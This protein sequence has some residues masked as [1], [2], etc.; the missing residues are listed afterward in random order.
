MYPLRRTGLVNQ[1]KIVSGWPFANVITVSQT[2][3]DADYSTIAAAITAASAGDVI[4]IDAGTYTE[5]ITVN[6]AIALTSFD[7]NKTEITTTS[8]ITISLTTSDIVLSNLKIIN[9]SSGVQGN[10]I[11][12]SSSADDC[13]VD[14]CILENNTAGNTNNGI[15]NVSGTGLVVRETNITIS[16]GTSSNFCYNGNTAANDVE[17]IRSKLDASGAGAAEIRLNH[18]NAFATITETI[19]INGTVAINANLG[20]FNGT[21]QDAILTKNSSGATAAFNDVGF[22]DVAGEYQTT[23]TEA[24]NVVW[25]VVVIGNDDD[26]NIFVKRRGNA[27]VNYTGAAPSAGDFLITSTTGG[28]ATQQVTMRSEIFAVATANGSGGTVMA[29]LLTGTESKTV[30]SSNEWFRHAAFADTSNFVA[31]IN[32]APT[33][34]SVVYN[35]P[36]AGAENTIAPIAG[37][38]TRIVLHCTAGAGIGTSRIMTAV[39]TGTNTITTVSSIDAWA[40]GDTITAQ[41]QTAVAAGPQFFYDL[42][43]TGQ[44][45]VPLLAR[46]IKFNLLA[47]DTGGAVTS[48]GHPFETNSPSKTVQ[49]SNEVAGGQVW[50]FVD[51]KL[52]EQKFCF[53]WGASGAATALPILRIQG[54]D[55]AVP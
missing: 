31:T 11:S 46:S 32:G 48:V 18:A 8:M 20:T 41:S 50:N 45:V 15:E 1:N 24:D 43:L 2:D 9:A 21:L 39:N 54:Y 5:A 53:S 19:L 28:S 22:L 6:K 55:L 4:L 37:M 52:T 10:C 30:T 34:T 36:S 26:D 51:I 16:A 25:C 23:T 14:N 13:V 33:P 42:E 7:V 3:Q 44:T 47:F 40:N 49:A 12:L 27:I 35:A 38:L 29:L 17:F